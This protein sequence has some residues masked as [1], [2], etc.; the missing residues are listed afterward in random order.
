MRVTLALLAMFVLG[1][2]TARLRWPFAR[3]DSEMFTVDL[4][5]RVLKHEGK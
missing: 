3:D 2:L 4:L 5:R 1:R